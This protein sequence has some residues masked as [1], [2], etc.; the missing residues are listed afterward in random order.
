MSWNNYVPLSMHM[1]SVLSGT[2]IYRWHEIYPVYPGANTFESE[3]SKFY[4]G[5]FGNFIP[6]AFAQN[7]IRLYV[8]PVTASRSNFSVNVAGT[9]NTMTAPTEVS[10]DAREVAIRSDAE[11]NGAIVVDSLNND[12][13]SIIGYAEEFTSAD[14]FKVLPPVS[15]PV[16]IYEYYAISVPVARI[17]LADTEDYDYDYEGEFEDPL[18][19]SAIVIVTTDDDTELTISLTQ[20]VMI[21]AQ[22]LLLQVPSGRYD[23]GVPVTLRFPG[24]SQTVYIESV[25]DLT[26]SLVTSNKPIAF[27][28]GH[29][30]GTVPN[31]FEYCDQLLEQVPP[32]ATW[33]KTFVTCPIEGRQSFDVFKVIA[34]RDSSVVNVSCTGGR[35]PQVL[36]LQRGEFAS[37]N[38]SSSSHCYVRSSRPVLL[39]QYSIVSSVDNVITGDPFMVIV[40]PVEQYRSSYVISA[41]NNSLLFPGFPQVFFVNILLPEGVDPSGMRMNGRPLNQTVSFIPV[42]CGSGGGSCGSSAQV[43]ISSGHHTLTH[44]NSS[45]VFDAIVY[46]LYYRVG[47]GYFAGMRQNPIARMSTS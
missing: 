43:S 25:D 16:D 44:E 35:P 47:S 32:T 18:G 39:V 34:S 22:D 1:H 37:F 9:S 38:V 29:E 31:D 21:T 27:M 6:P 5:F 19:N 8:S 36:N 26:G 7:N 3:G 30:C 15:L 17:P 2:H 11:R 45:A 28:S 42:P 24:A 14:T 4:F 12:T 41:L 40:P 46:W 13:L 10:M 23:A 33:G 20:T